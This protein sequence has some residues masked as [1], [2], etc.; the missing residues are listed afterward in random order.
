[1]IKYALI[2]R[3]QH[4]FDGWFSSIKDYDDQADGGLVQC[5]Y[6]A[7]PDVQKAIMAP[8]VS[9][10]RKKEATAAKQARALSMMNDAAAKIRAEIADKCVDVGDKF[11]DE[12]RA[13]H[14]GEKDARAIY[15]QA[16]PDEA[17]ALVEDGIAI[18]P[19]PDILTPK[20]KA[21]LN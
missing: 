9:T 1:M 12:A 13:I 5:P 17:Q 20:P 10:S 4:S 8:A 7:T 19:L 15:G 21:K 6:C 11:A 3:N 16:S 18:A 14:Y 2:C